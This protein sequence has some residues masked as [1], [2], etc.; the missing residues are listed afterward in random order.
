MRTVIKTILGTITA[1]R[2]T[3]H[4]YLRDQKVRIVAVLKHAARA[5]HDP[6]VDG[7][8][9]TDE[10]DLLRAGGVDVG[11]RVEVQPWLEGEGRFSFVSSD[12]RAIDLACFAD[13]AS[14]RGAA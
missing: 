12:P 7:S 11:D 10:D 4:P 8:Y 6:D 13:L 5:D 2:G 9:I 14:P 1:Y 3:E